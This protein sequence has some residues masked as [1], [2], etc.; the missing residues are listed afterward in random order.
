GG[1]LTVTFNSDALDNAGGWAAV[2][3]CVPSCQT[4]LADLVSTNPASVPLDTGWIDICPGERIFFNGAGIYPQN[5][6][7]Y[8]QSDLTT[9]FE[10]NFGDGGI[11]YGPGTSH[12]YQEPGGYIV[13]LFLTDDQGCRSTNYINQ[14]VRV[15]PRPSFQL[16]GAVP[17]AICA[18]DTIHLN[19]AVNATSNGQTL[20]VAPVTAS[21][22]VEGSRS[23]SLA[24][25]DGTGI[26]YETSIF[27]TDFSPGQ[28][29]TDPNDLESI[30]VNMEHSWMRD[31]EISITCPNGQSII[32]HNFGGQTGSEILLG[33]PNDNDLFNPIPGVGYDYCWTPNAPNPTWLQYANTNL[34]VG[35][36]LPAGD[37]SPYQPFSG[38]VGCPLNGEWTITV[39]DLWPIDN[40]Y[41]FSWGIKF[42]DALYP[43][44]E[45]FTPAID[46][47]NWNSHPTIFYATPDSISATPQNGGTAGYVFTVNDAFGCSWDTL[48]SIPVY[49]FTHPACHTCQENYALLQDTTICESEPVSL[50]AESF[51]QDTFEVRFEAFPDYAIGNSN[52]PHNNPYASP[53][54]VNS[55]GYNLLT[56]PAAQITSICMDIE[57][58]FDADLNIFLRSPDGK[59]LELSTGNGAAGDNYKITCFSPTAT[60]PIVGNAAPFNGTYMPEG[61]WASLNNAVVN[62]NWSLLVSDG[63]GI[64]QFGKVKWW[65]IGFNYFNS[66]NYSWT[67]AA[68][69]SCGNC[70]DPVASPASSTIYVVIAT[71]KF[72]CVH[73]DTATITVTNLFPAPANL[74]ASAIGASSITWTW[75][76]VAGAS[77]YEVSIN[78]GAWQ[79]AN[80][81]LAHTVAGLISGDTV[82]IE[83][84]A[85]GG[86]VTCLPEASSDTQIFVVCTL[87]ASLGGTM[88]TLCAGTPTG[89]ATIS[90]TGAVLPVEYILNG[91]GPVY[92]NGNLNNILP[93][94]DQY[95]VVR[96]ADGC[97]DTVYFTITEPA[98]LDL[99]A[100]ATDALCNGD[101]DGTVTAS[102]SGG[103]GNINYAWQGCAGGAVYNMAV[104]G[105][106]YAG[107]YAVTATDANGCSATDSVTIGEPPVYGFTSVQDSVSCNGGMDGSATILV[108]GGSPPYTYVWSGIGGNTPTITGLAAGFYFVNVI[109]SNACEAATFVQVFEPPPLVFDSITFK[110]VSCFGG[111]NGT[112]TVFVHG[113]MPPYT[114][115]WNNTQTTQKA[116]NL[117]VGNYSVVVT[118]AGGCSVSA[119]VVVTS[120]DELMIGFGNVVDEK[121]AGDCQGQATA[122]VTGGVMPYSYLWSTPLPNT[123]PGITGLCPGSYMVTVEDANGCTA[124]EKVTINAAVPIDI[125]LQ[126]VPPACAGDNNG[127]LEAVVTG[128]ETPYQIQWSAGGT[129]AILPNIPCGNYYMTLTDN[130]GCVKS[131]SAFLPCP[132]PVEI[133]SITAEKTSCFGTPDGQITVEA[134]G[135]TGQLSY[136]W[137]DPNA[138]ID[139]VATNLP[140]GVYTVTVSDG[141]GC[142]ATASAG[143]TEPSALTVTLSHTDVSCFNGS[144]GTVTANTFGGTGP[145]TYTWNTPQSDQKI[146]DLPA[147]TYFV[148]VMDA[149]GCTTTANTNITEPATAVEVMVTQTVFACFGE[150]NGAATAIAMGGNGSPFNYQ[151]SNNQI[152]PN[153]TGLAAGTITVTATDSKG[154]SAVAG[155][156]TQQL[157][158]I[159]ANIAFVPPSCHGYNDGQAAVNLVTG[160]IGMG[161]TTKYNYEWSVPNSP[162]SI[163]VGNL[164]G[165]QAYTL[166]ITDLQGCSGTFSFFI[167]QPPPIVAQIATQNVSCNGLSDGSLQVTGIQGA[168]LPAT[169]TWSNSTT[170]P[171]ISNLAA[172]NYILTIHAADGCIEQD[173]LTVTEPAPLA[174]SFEIMPLLCSGDNNASVEAMISGGTPGYSVNWN[175]GGTGTQ[176]GNLGPGIYTANVTDMN[177]CVL[178]DSTTVERPDSMTIQ[179]EKTDPGCFGASNGQ[180]R[181]YVSGGQMPYRYSIDGVNFGGS[182]SFIGLKA[183]VYTILIRDNNSCITAYT[184][185]LLQPPAVMVALGP[186]TTIVLGDSVLV[187]PDVSDAFGMVKYKWR[188]VLVEDLMCLDTPECSMIWAKPYQTNTYIVTVTDENGCKGSDDIVVNVIKPRGAYVPTGFS[189]NGDLTNDLL[190][191][192]GKS[193]QIRRVVS[194]RVYDRWGE[195]LYEDSDFSV[196]D[197]TRGWD[198]SFR[199]RNCDPGV[200][201]WYV[202]VEYRDGYRESLSGNVTL[203]R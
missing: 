198:G 138:Q 55:M 178:T 157:A 164:P 32:L 169:Y 80:G 170:G 186:D 39:T 94:G 75:D 38:L 46:S 126:A 61:N 63:F 177:G 130:A 108:T 172:G 149:N 163:Y 131:D 176:I 69:L 167:T 54:A 100:S 62:G 14:R 52:H 125:H 84:R 33:I 171:G 160:G 71:D 31:M 67:N 133:L 68:S 124:D 179:V 193:L 19:A 95:V 15:A 194:F 10:W 190:V 30:C 44:I 141:N 76:A 158:E 187:I 137:N 23:D 143:I 41:I 40:G 77:G 112:A 16:T 105:G 173:T 2:I 4:V 189:P 96:D 182:S 36:T 114:Y 13:Q 3:S 154:C 25:P 11:S 127:S 165:G 97:K 200:Y 5:G 155:I 121:C 168:S 199:G 132:E 156:E 162:N 70:P 8:Q 118:D 85:I 28:V 90:V 185:S 153:A 18:G 104:V 111:N 60:I 188:S 122:Q 202:E 166:T 140:V 180:I 201:V 109:D 49:P 146:T 35:G 175:N 91:S 99:T 144:D 7:S 152:G 58:D 50:N 1:C 42:K 65:S 37:Y 110:A 17:A 142:S 74:N 64:S 116:L 192:Y 134:Q 120:P 12:A 184:D 103:T 139:S 150:N 81:S 123:Q 24:L 43:N 115:L 148:T 83:V 20:A 87:D 92:P 147:G 21:F 128:G 101:P 6:L 48:I 151:W 79:P 117:I 119:S 181:L 135:G 9:I 98:A 161:D 136:L 93:A 102:A 191:V 34:P 53:I 66:V 113:G 174:V 106:L 195:K 26:P 107:C 56:N 29:L 47:W 203:I 86:S 196:N 59:L 22:S 183:G 82:N 197:E 159:D 89:S 51:G 129:G 88:P 57:T 73:H 145:F 45:T 72:N 78:G 27:F